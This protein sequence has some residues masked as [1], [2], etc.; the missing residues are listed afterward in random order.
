[1][2][3]TG[4]P[5]ECSYHFAWGNEIVKLSPDWTCPRESEHKS[6]GPAAG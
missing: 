5:N 3:Y 1:M 4:A 2:L 6:F